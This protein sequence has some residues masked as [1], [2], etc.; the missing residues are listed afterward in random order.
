MRRKYFLFLIVFLVGGLVF[1]STVRALEGE[2]EAKYDE[3]IKEY[4][5]K[6]NNLQPQNKEQLEMIQH[7]KKNMEEYERQQIE[8]SKV[9]EEGIKKWKEEQELWE[10]AKLKWE[11][12]KKLFEESKGQMAKSAE[13]IERYDKILDTWEHQQKQYQEYL[14]RLDEEYIKSRLINE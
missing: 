9:R 13:Q 5:N 14:D 3:I 7:Y 8:A 11:E 1:V 6:T 12:E 4:E 2:E 10:E